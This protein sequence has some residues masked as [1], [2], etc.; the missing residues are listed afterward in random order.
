MPI[1]LAA[2]AIVELRNAPLSFINLCNP[3]PVLWSTLIKH[4]ASSLNVPLVPYN[5]WY[6]RLEKTSYQRF[7]SGDAGI[8]SHN[9]V[10]KLVGFYGSL[11]DQ[12]NEETEAFM[13]NKFETNSVK[14]TKSLGNINISQL[15][16]RDVERSLAHWK[17]TRAVD[18]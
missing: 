17:K 10:Y 11:K 18:I 1:D 7:S 16:T 8:I 14:L 15:D 12:R 6:T 2:S 13:G 9:P 3:T 4:Y 5:E